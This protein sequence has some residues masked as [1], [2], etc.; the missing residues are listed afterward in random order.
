MKRTPVIRAIGAALLLSGSGLAACAPA[1]PPSA[2]V[3]DRVT[4][5]A[6]VE[7]VDMRSRDVLLRGPGGALFT[8]KAGPEVRNLAQVRSGDRVHV[9]Y[10]E[11][12]AVQVSPPGQMGQPSERDTAI[13]RA[14]RGER[15]AGAGFDMI[16]VRVKIEAVDRATNTVTFM[17]PRGVQHIVAVRNPEMIAFIRRIRPGDEVELNYVEAVAVSVEPA[18]AAAARPGSAPPPGGRR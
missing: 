6:T 3:E 8:V 7:S 12:L 16:R 10:Q 4:T 18:P 2:V 1:T 17:D 14:A 5:V 11:A 15:P 13:V 9:A